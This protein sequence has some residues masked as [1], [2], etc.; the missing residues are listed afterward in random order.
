VR[1]ESA[2]DRAENGNPKKKTWQTIWQARQVVRTPGN[3]E[4]CD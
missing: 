2:Q 4:Q 3:Q 1:H